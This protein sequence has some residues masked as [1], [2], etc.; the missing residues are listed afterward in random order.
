MWWEHK[1][2]AMRTA[3]RIPAGPPAGSTSRRRHRARILA[4]LLAICRNIEQLQRESAARQAG[5]D[6]AA[7][8]AGALA[9]ETA[10]GRASRKR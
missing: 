5:R 10:A 9:R 4:T 6:I 7:L 2:G 1:T 8:L 3:R